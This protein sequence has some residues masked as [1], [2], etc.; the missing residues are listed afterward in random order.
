MN[1]FLKIFIRKTHVSV[2]FVFPILLFFSFRRRPHQQLLEIVHCFIKIIVNWTFLY[3]AH[4]AFALT[5]RDHIT[6]VEMKS[7]IWKV[8]FSISQF[9][10]HYQNCLKGHLYITNH[11][12]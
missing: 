1:I 5:V 3:N 11:C 4:R 9:Q 2:K 12:L 6:A 10:I 8:L 7:T